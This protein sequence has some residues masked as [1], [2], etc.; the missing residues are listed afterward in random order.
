ML[1]ERDKT[2]AHLDPEGLI[3]RTQ[4]VAANWKI[5]TNQWSG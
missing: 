4:V 3:S 2:G 5:E 1:N